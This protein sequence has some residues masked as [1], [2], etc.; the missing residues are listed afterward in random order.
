VIFKIIFMTVIFSSSYAMEHNIHKEPSSR[1][2]AIAK[3]ETE[4]IKDIN[5]LLDEMEENLDNLEANS[6]RN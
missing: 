3:L 4:T 2:T 1:E 6:G 5:K